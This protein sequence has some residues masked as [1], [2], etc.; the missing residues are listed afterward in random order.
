MVKPKKKDTRIRYTY[1]PTEKALV[2]LR[3]LG[4]LKGNGY[5]TNK[6]KSLSGLINRLMSDFIDSAGPCLEKAY[7]ELH[8]RELAKEHNKLFKEIDRL[9]T[10]KA[11]LERQSL[12]ARQE[13][14][15][16][17]ISH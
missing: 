1:H 14:Q 7:V 12:K 11:D 8:I 3:Y 10:L 4:Y 15:L 16:A 2:A 5:K 9:Q 13:Q 17:N 6:E